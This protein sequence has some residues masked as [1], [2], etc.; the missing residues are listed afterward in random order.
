MAITDKQAEI[1]LLLHDDM[2]RAIARPGRNVG[3]MLAQ[4]VMRPRRGDPSGDHP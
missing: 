2:K 4:L 1:F 3:R